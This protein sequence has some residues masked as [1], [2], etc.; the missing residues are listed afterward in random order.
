[1]ETDRTG[2]PTFS[3]AEIR[4]EFG[5]SARA[6]RYYEERMLLSPARPGG[7]RRYSEQDRA[8]LAMIIRGRKVGLSLV[9]IIEIVN[10]HPPGSNQQ[11][12]AALER[13]GAQIVRLQRRRAEIGDAITA[14]QAACLRLEGDKAGAAPPP[15]L[16]P[17]AVRHDL[18]RMFGHDT[19]TT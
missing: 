18:I 15:D 7:Y 8:R 9:D 2:E 12:R 13:F 3:I 17:V 1:M 6:L 4:R 19:A 16:H 5:V 14:L 10:G 11:A